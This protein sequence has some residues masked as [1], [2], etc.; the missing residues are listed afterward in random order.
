MIL[1]GN[2]R[3]VKDLSFS[4]YLDVAWAHF[5]R[6]AGS[7]NGW[8][9]PFD[10]RHRIIFALYGGEPPVEREAPESRPER[11]VG[12]TVE[13]RRPGVPDPKLAQLRRAHEQLEAL[14]AQAA[15]RSATSITPSE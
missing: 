6:I 4:D 2:P 14:K 8:V 10:V 7:A 15:T 5:L 12:D 1:A 9:D 13:R 3:G 11:G